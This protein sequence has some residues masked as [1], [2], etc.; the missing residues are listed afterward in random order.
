[1]FKNVNMVQL[2]YTHRQNNVNWQQTSTLAR[3]HC[4]YLKL[5][6]MQIPVIKSN[7]TVADA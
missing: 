6:T 3:E 5:S 1:M 7:T 2:I 4:A